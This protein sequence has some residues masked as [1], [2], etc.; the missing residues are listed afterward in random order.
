MDLII[1]VGFTMA[2]DI[3]NKQKIIQINFAIV[4]ETYEEIPSNVTPILF[5]ANEAAYLTGLIAGKMTKL[6]KLDL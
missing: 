5:R 2:E 6:M 1:G 3:K 4:D